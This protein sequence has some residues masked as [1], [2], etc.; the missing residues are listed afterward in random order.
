MSTQQINGILFFDWFGVVFAQSR[1]H[2]HQ[3][4]LDI[5]GNRVLRRTNMWVSVWVMWAVFAVV[6]GLG[7][8]HTCMCARPTAHL[9]DQRRTWGRAERRYFCLPLRRN[10]QLHLFQMSLAPLTLTVM[11]KKAVGR[12]RNKIVWGFIILCLF[13]R[14][15]TSF[16][17]PFLYCSA[18]LGPRLEFLYVVTTCITFV[19]VWVW[20]GETKNRSLLQ[21]QTLLFPRGYLC[22]SGGSTSFNQ[23]KNPMRSTMRI[24]LGKRV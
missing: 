1:L 24:L 12:N 8:M 20:V 14:C 7:T 19:Y 9:F 21:I 6:G 17:R 3:A 11:S 10:L 16:R 22:A 15:L 2:R 13:A 23:R 18:I 4:G 5:L